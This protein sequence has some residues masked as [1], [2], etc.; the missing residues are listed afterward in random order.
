MLEVTPLVGWPLVGAAV[1]TL[2][3]TVG[4]SYLLKRGIILPGTTR[5]WIKALGG[6]TLNTAYRTAIDQAADPDQ[7]LL[8]TS[9]ILQAFAEKITGRQIPDKAC[10]N[11][12]NILDVLF[13]HNGFFALRQ[14]VEK[15]PN[16]P[17]A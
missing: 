16:P 14:L 5:G 7:Q 15:F 1:I 13:M 17:E 2:A 6:G 8:I 9:A 4:K 11:I 12:V 3:L 10:L